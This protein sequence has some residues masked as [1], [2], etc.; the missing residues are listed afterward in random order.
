MSPRNN[1]PWNA[2]WERFDRLL[3]AER[4][5]DA[6]PT[7][8]PIPHRTTIEIGQCTVTFN[9]KFLGKSTVGAITYYSFE[10]DTPPVAM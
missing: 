2:G 3:A 8:S 10:G 6:I 5:F 7:P 9:G 4:L 1:R